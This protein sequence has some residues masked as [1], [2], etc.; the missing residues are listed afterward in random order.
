MTIQAR[1]ITKAKYASTAFTGEGARRFGH[2]WSSLGLS[3]VYTAESTSLAMLEILVHVQSND[4]L[5]NY[6]VFPLSFDDAL[7]VSIDQSK[8]P[9]NWRASP[10]DDSLRQFGDQWAT[11]AD[12]AVL[13]V[14]SAV[15]PEESNYVLNP[16]HPDFAKIDVGEAVPIDFDPRLKA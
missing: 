10:A 1:R 9:R 14:P 11:H 8:L 2:R 15:A 6:V 5:K 12:S 7:V 3:V 13:R 16:A 4:A